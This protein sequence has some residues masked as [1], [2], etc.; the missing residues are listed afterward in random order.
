MKSDQATFTVVFTTV[1]AVAINELIVRITL[2]SQRLTCFLVCRK[3]FYE[4][5]MSSSMI[6]GDNFL[7]NHNRESVKN[8]TKRNS[9]IS[10]QQTGKDLKDWSYQVMTWSHKKRFFLLHTIGEYCVILDKLLL[11][12]G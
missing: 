5:L 2:I 8:I 4:K 11:H 10:F 3:I 6:T 7:N 1:S 9:Q 12:P